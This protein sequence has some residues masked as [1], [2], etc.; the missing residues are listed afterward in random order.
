LV[1]FVGGVSVAKENTSLKSTSSAVLNPCAKGGSTKYLHG[2]AGNDDDHTA[3]ERSTSQTALT[4][5]E[6]SRALLFFGR[7]AQ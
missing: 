2:T 6:L 5:L 1:K 4:A 7:I 3:Q